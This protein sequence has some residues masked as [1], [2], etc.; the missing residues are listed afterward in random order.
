MSYIYYIASDTQKTFAYIEFRPATIGSN[1]YDL[2]VANEYATPFTSM[3]E[4]LLTW[5][6]PIKSE[7]SPVGTARL[8]PRVRQ[9]ISTLTDMYLYKLN[10]QKL[11]AK[12]SLLPV[13]KY[14]FGVYPKAEEI[15][16]IEEGALVTVS[17]SMHQEGVYFYKKLGRT[18]VPQRIAD[19]IKLEQ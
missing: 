11:T 12:K 4:G 15:A 8:T 5:Y 19:L 6:S 7:D 10:L 9:D 18:L 2:V 17:Q 13:V 3:Y 14:R 1:R 16:T